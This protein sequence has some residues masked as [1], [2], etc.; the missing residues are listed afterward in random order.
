[1]KS[2][3]TKRVMVFIAVA[4]VLAACSKNDEGMYDYRPAADN[5]SA[6][7][8][9]RWYQLQLSLIK[10]TTPSLGF[11][12]PVAARAFGYTG[13]ALYETVVGGMPNYK[14]IASQIGINTAMPAPPASAKLNWGVAAN[15]C[16]AQMTRKLFT[17]ATTENLASINSLENQ[18]Q[19]EI[20]TADKVNTSI[21]QSAL[22]GKAIAQAVF[23]WSET[24]GGANGATQPNGNGYVAPTGAG[25]WVP[26]FPAYAAA[27]LPTWGTNRPFKNSDTSGACM[28]PPPINFT[29]AAGTAFHAQAMAVVNAKAALTAEQTIIARYWADGGGSITPPGH[30]IA[31]TSQLIEQN[32]LSLGEAS[33]IYA[34]MGMAV[35]DAFIACWRGKYKYNIMR[36]I[37]YI[38]QNIDAN[39]RPLITTP[40]FPEYCSGHSTQSGA[41]AEI[42][43]TH[44]GNNSFTDNIKQWDGGFA[45]RSFSSFY[46]AAQEAAVSRLY[47]GIH[48]PMANDRGYEAGL[49]IARNI[50]SIQFKK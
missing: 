39:W 24:D 41:M 20:A 10:Q 12:P 50:N 21:E 7:V 8:P 49:N 9:A 40:P 47:G 46:A 13:V 44:F 36:P 23:T 45:P 19:N 6:N 16:M 35:A 4:T 3:L 28:P 17:L 30:S 18:I 37:T 34:K 42:L 11:A 38:N 31:I 5:Y 48:Y 14:S 2:F 32:T 25:M 43:T 26:T 15:A 1:M 33:I 27:L 29:T 22:Y